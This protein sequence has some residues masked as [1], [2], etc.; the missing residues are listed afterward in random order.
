MRAAQDDGYG[1]RIAR[2]SA[3]WQWTAF[4]V[5]GRPLETGAAPN[6]ATAAA[7]VIRV[8]ARE[9]APGL[10]ERARAAS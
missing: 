9:H 5:A 1:F 2:T 7:C 3:G 6:R 4:D 10:D 8:I